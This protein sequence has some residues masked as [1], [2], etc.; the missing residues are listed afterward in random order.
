MESLFTSF[1]NA[2]ISGSVMIAA[3]VLLRL[4]LRRSPRHLVCLLW[5]PVAAL[6]MGLYEGMK[7]VLKQ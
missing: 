1:L 2:G 7:K 3:V 4:L 6:A 5:I